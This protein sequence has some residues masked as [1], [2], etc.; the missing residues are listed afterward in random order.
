VLGEY[1]LDF[2]SNYQSWFFLIFQNQ[3]TVEVRIFLFK[4]IRIK[5]PPVLIFQDLERS[6]SF[7][8]RAGKRIHKSLARLFWTTSQTLRT[9]VIYPRPTLVETNDHGVLELACVLLCW[10]LHLSLSLYIQNITWK[11]FEWYIKFKSNSD[12]LAKKTWIQPQHFHAQK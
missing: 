8:E 3:K 11:Y 6:N 1:L 10:H 4:K 12:S 9:K 2:V 5:E 7:H